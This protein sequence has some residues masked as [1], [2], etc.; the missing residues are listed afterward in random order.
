MAEALSCKA[1]SSYAVLHL[2]GLIDTLLF[3]S[4]QQDAPSWSV[5]TG[6]L[7]HPTRADVDD[8]C[9]S[10]R[11]AHGKV[12]AARFPRRWQEDVR[13]QRAEPMQSE[14]ILVSSK[15]LDFLG[16]DFIMSVHMRQSL[17]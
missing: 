5:G 12:L 11:E 1:T 15:G 8:G 7:S 17:L 14:R 9:D 2:N 13:M 10:R 3:S 4:H 16:R 6:E